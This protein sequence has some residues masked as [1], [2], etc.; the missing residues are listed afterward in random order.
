M[1][2]RIAKASRK[3]RQQIKK[4]NAKLRKIAIFGKST[5]NP[6]N[7]FDAK[8]VNDCKNYLNW[9]CGPTLRRE[10]QFHN[11]LILIQKDK[12]SIILNKPSHIGASRLELSI[13][14]MYD[15]FHYKYIITKLNYF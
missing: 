3:R 4:Q 10:T 7:N 14:L 2:Y 15:D 9:S 11:G 5:E 13:V 12:C 6:M 1:Q 8:I